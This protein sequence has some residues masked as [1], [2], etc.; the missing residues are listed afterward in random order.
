MRFLLIFL[1]LAGSAGASD[2]ELL[3]TKAVALF[4]REFGETDGVIAVE[5]NPRECLRTGYQRKTRKVVFCQGP[6]VINGGL[7][8]VDVI[9]HEFFHAL[10][11]G[12]FPDLCA[13]DED[14]HVHEALA[15]AFAYRLNPDANFGENFYT[16]HDYIRPY[17]T[18][19]I[20]ELVQSEHEQGWA[21]ASRIIRESKP[22][23]ESM[24]LFHSSIDSFVSVTVEGAP[25]SKLNRYRLE[26][27]QELKLS[28]RFSPASGVKEVAWEL[29]PGVEADTTIRITEGF[30]G[31]KA[32]ARFLSSDKKELGRWTFYFGRKI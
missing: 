31:G 22:L 20:P 1:F 10:F 14:D 15:D 27:G 9:N 28:F 17:K 5:L 18:D 4:T 2:L 30:T 11:C 29:P 16:D 19:W 6:R 21:L 3:R 12:K 25:A 32:H 23:A 26:P 24:G 13:A 7:E 8:S